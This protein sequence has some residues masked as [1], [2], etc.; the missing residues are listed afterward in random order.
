MSTPVLPNTSRSLRKPSRS[1]KMTD[2][3]RHLFVTTVM[4]RDQHRELFAVSVDL[5]VSVH[6]RQ[7]VE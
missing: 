4:V 6:M 5:V 7:T 2:L 3:T 1:A